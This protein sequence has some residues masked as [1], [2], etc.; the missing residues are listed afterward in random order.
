MEFPT[1]SSF[2]FSVAQIVASRLVVNPFLH[3]FLLYHKGD[4]QIGKHYKT[5]KRLA[6]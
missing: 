1:L 6:G 5:W 3:L 2:S 4:D